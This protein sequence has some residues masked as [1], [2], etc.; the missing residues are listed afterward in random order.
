MT[1]I[2]STSISLPGNPFIGESVDLTLGFDNTG[3]QTGYGPFVL[4]Y[5]D[6]TGADGD[7]G[8]TFN[9]ATYLGS[10]V[11]TTE[12]QL[13]EDPENPPALAPITFNVFGVEQ[14]I[15]SSDIPSDFSAGDTLVVMELPFGS[16]VVDQ[17]QA[18]IAVNLTGS[19]LA[20]LNTP[21]NLQSQG[22]FVFGNTATEETDG[23]DD[24][25]YENIS[26][27]PVDTVTPQLVTLTKNYIGPED[28]TATGPNFVRQFELVV[29]IAD[30]QTIENL[31]VTDILPDDMQF[32]DVVS[33]VDSNG[34]INSSRI[35]EVATPDDGGLTSI[36]SVNVTENDVNSDGVPTPGGTLSRRID[37]VT[38]TS[39]ERDLVLTYEFFIPRLDANSDVIINANS[40][41]DIISTNESQLGDN[42]DTDSNNTWDPVDTRDT[43]AEVYVPST[44]TDPNVPTHDLEDQSIAIQKSVSN[45]TDSENTPGD[46]LEY[47][48]D[49]Q[50][51][52]YFAFQNIDIF[53]TFSDGQRFDTSFTP[54]FTVTEHGQ[55]STTANFDLTNY[56]VDES[57]IGNDTLAG[58]DGTTEVTFEISDELIT[59]NFDDGDGKLVGGGVPDGGFQDGG[60]SLENNP[61][62]PQGATEGTITFRTVIQQEYSDTYD[63]GDASVDIG[64]KL[65]NSAIIDGEVL[66]VDNLNATGQS[67]D[68]DTSA[69]V[70]IQE[71]ELY[72]SIYAIN[73]EIFTGADTDTDLSDGLTGYANGVNIS[74]GDEVTYRLTY[75]LPTTDVEDLT[76]TDYFPLPIYDAETEFA[77][78]NFDPT[79]DSSVPSAGSTKYGPLDTFSTR[80]DAGGNNPS[81]TFSVSDDNT[82]KLTYSYADFDDD[83]NQS[84]IVD[85]L[86]TV[87]AYDEPAADGLLYTNQVRETNRTTFNEDSFLDE[88]IQ[89]TLDQPEVLEITKGVVAY[90][91]NGTS[92]PNPNF[93]VP[94]GVSFATG[95]GTTYTGTSDPV[96]SLDLDSNPIDSNLT[97]SLEAGDLVTFAITVENTGNSRTGVFDV[98]LQDDLPTG[99]TIPNSGLNLNITDGTGAT[100]GYTGLDDND[101]SGDDLFGTGIELVDPGSDPNTDAGALNAYD[102]NSG[103]NIAVVTFDLEVDD[104]APYQDSDDTRDQEQLTNT[105]TLVS[106]ANTDNNP[107]VFTAGLTDTATVD[108][109]LPELTKSIISTSEAHTSEDD[110]GK[111]A[112]N[113]SRRKL[114]IGE[115]VR[116][117]LLTAI[118]EGTANNFQIEDNLP[119]GF[120]FLNDN[121]A[122]AAFISDQAPIA[123][124]TTTTNYDNPLDIGLG[125]FA[126]FSSISGDPNQDLWIQGTTADIV[127]PTFS[128]PDV[129]VGSSIS[130]GDN[131]QPADPDVP[132]PDDYN[133]STDIYFK[134]GDLNNP[135]RDTNEEYVV[136][137]F[138]ALLANDALDNNGNVDIN[139]E[140]NN[141]TNDFQVRIG[142]GNNFNSSDTLVL[143]EDINLKI[144]E[145]IISLTKEVSDNSS[146][147]NN[148]S[149]LADS[150]DTVYFSLTFDNKGNQ[151]RRATAFEVNLTDT[152][153]DGLTLTG[154]ESINWNNGDGSGGSG[155]TNTGIV[156][157]DDIDVGDMVITPTFDTVTGA[158][159]VD[160][161][162]M[163]TDA[164]I[165]I[166]YSA[167]VDSDV[168]PDEL[169][170]NTADITYS[171][172]PGTGTADNATGSV[173]PG[174]SGSTTGERNGDSTTNS[175]ND[176]SASASGNVQIDPLVPTKTLRSTSET[177]TSTESEVTIGEIVR[178]RLAVEIP[179]GETAGFTI[180][181]D[182]PAG[183]TYIG[184]PKLAFVADGTGTTSGV[185]SDDP[186][187]LNNPQVTDSS[188]TNPTYDLTTG[189]TDA[190]GDS[191]FT[192]GEDVTF[193]LGNITNADDDSDEEYVVV[194]FNALV[195]N[196]DA[197]DNGDTLANSFQVSASSPTQTQTSDPV[198][199]TITEPILGSITHTASPETGDAGDTITY[200]VTFSNDGS[201]TAYDLNITD[202]LPAELD[203]LAISS[204]SVTIFDD[205]DTPQD[206]TS[207]FTVNATSTS[208]TDGTSTDNDNVDAFD[209]DLNELPANYSVEIQYTATIVGDITTEASIDNTVDVTYSSLPGEDL[210]GTD[211]NNPGTSDTNPTGSDVNDTTSG[212]ADS[213]RNSSSNGEGTSVNN[214]AISST[215]TVTVDPLV[216]VKRLVATS[217]SHTADDDVAIGEIVRYQLEVKIP[218]GETDGF[219]ITDDLPAGLK[220]LGNP[221][222]AFVADDS[223]NGIDSTAITDADPN[224]APNLDLTGTA[225]TTPE[226]D[227]TTGITD[228][229]GDSNFTSGEDV[230]FSLGDLTNSDRDSED[231]EYVVIEFNALVENV[232]DNTDGG[233]NDPLRNEFTVSATGATDRTSNPVDVD[234]VEPS[235]IDVS[236]TVSSTTADAGDPLT[237][238]ITFS[239]T[240]T[241]DAFDLN[242]TDT[243][244][245]GLDNLAVS[246]VT[247]FDETNTAINSPGY[248]D[249]STSSNDGTSTDDPNADVLDIDINQLPVGYS[250]EIQYTADVVGDI[251]PESEIN[252]TVD[253]TYT[254][255]DG[256]GTANNDTGSDNTAA[257][258]GDAD[259][260]RNG[261]GTG[262]NTYTDSNDTA[263]S[264]TINSLNAVKTLAST[265]ETSTTNSDV[266]IGETVR[267]Q[268]A[269]ELPEGQTD[270]FK[271]TDAI[272][273]GITYSGNAKV[274]FVANDDFAGSGTGIDSSTISGS[275]IDIEGSAAATPTFDLTTGISSEIG[276]D[277][278]FTSGEDVTFDLGN[279]TNTDRDSDSEYVVIEFDGIVDGVGSNA[280]L[281]NT[282]TVTAGSS[283]NI[284]ATSG[285]TT[286]DVTLDYGDA[287]D[288]GSTT[289]S[290]GDY[291][292]LASSNGASHGIR[293]GLTIGTEIDA[294]GGNLQNTTAD[295]DDSSDTG[296][297][298]D[299][300]GVESFSILETGADSYTVDVEVL[301]NTGESATLVGWIDFN[302]N[303]NFES[304]EAVIA[305]VPDSTTTA[306]PISLIWDRDTLTGGTVGDGYGELP[307]INDIVS[308]DTYA[309]FRLSTDADL[310]D[311]LSTGIV[312]DGE[313][314][315][316]QLTIYNTVDGNPYS[317]TIT[318][319]NNVPDLITAGEGQDTLTG[320]TGEDIFVYTKTSDGVDIIEDFEDGTDKI[321]LSALVASGGELDGI[322]FTD[323][324]FTDGYVE[325]V[326]FGSHTMIQVDFDNSDTL[327]KDV[328][329]L[330]NINSANITADDFIF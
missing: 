244:P 328:V 105:A 309:R 158:M 148:T 294:D 29:D 7:D 129:N 116:F 297:T 259:G 145:P 226:F 174:A 146:S 186:N 286:V 249:N 142:R 254:S 301:N 73:G 322:P 192:S 315:D 221:K 172:L 183:L 202:T 285:T 104:I 200:T 163:P 8:L 9:S 317:D 277:T 218:E 298:N 284:T 170:T 128:L 267:Y 252:S 276:D 310:D 323:D 45:I 230:T 141:R 295:A 271:I 37:S 199:V 318:E 278:T 283:S 228:A 97:E 213:E 107:N 10:A 176:Y 223:T 49:F 127:S 74:P 287:P 99:F 245:T 289:P 282:F 212:N 227:L 18:D 257:T 133:A 193:S 185:Y 314:E 265:S 262:A 251:A 288:S 110:D 231:D 319:A 17:P 256:T 197:N 305:D 44:S 50:V 180:T 312:D 246:S 190:S 203:N 268:L 96:S 61:P 162:Q 11:T 258:S 12:Y 253:L 307:N 273:N 164:E 100:I 40:G 70:T 168:N 179:E 169:I 30:G 330:N 264:V 81:L 159:A 94:S 236:Q 214:Y 6:T 235:V 194:E 19:D 272:P 111:E 124:T 91:T 112:T 149:L 56:I 57:Q 238:T 220:Y 195:E 36:G 75:E 88:I 4:F 39:G 16:F 241:A 51:S 166:I 237:Y 20:D 325:A 15:A 327:P 293:T 67:E 188:F 177:A 114:A 209:I 240:G 35:T 60:T 239:N 78:T 108:I 65:D 83:D 147:F 156:S 208:S 125:D 270:N 131:T 207:S 55:T 72:K 76:L 274:A 143:S 2:P 306:N 139:N 247:I 269:V 308:G 43:D 113:A 13:S 206:V 302:R 109:E 41:D 171:S 210:D 205:S 292:T 132:D 153:P 130:I 101:G 79:V 32:V 222:I 90:N 261:S 304:E 232:S 26:G 24:P 89:V 25:I 321:D 167:T 93:T 201:A 225:A 1:A 211:S 152:V 62:L 42:D 138:N 296:S 80:T 313:V 118:P 123:S 243:L 137:E 255:L 64:D 121:T 135:D 14:T 33:I 165:E 229:S 233:T 311:A 242:L 31:D 250:V 69:A 248:T 85:I 234:I 182:L 27:D 54:T 59:R 204:N 34:T 46:V 84:S 189:I 300:D 5:V 155:N 119:N 291:L 198:N 106:Y 52:D 120:V 3:T 216:P 329:L 86:V 187:I 215:E 58:T 303:G 77:S 22:G 217:E 87:T 184:N 224:T 275:G 280:S 157:G 219:S 21:I 161:D 47:T 92:I 102:D 191:T 324:P 82:N 66:D 279:L 178:Y 71:G 98:T 326:S 38:G 316:Y 151:N 290:Q 122:K 126:D 117:R 320:G 68:D 136:I 63:S 173:T 144:A 23:S 150:G 28:E 53:D 95:G 134:F 299:E 115:I 48:I 160:V 140:N 175:A 266:I 196:I 263:T 260:E 181:D 154:I 103:E 281:D